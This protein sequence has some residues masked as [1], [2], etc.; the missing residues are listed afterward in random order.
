M[1]DLKAHKAVFIAW[2]EN[3]F[4]GDLLNEEVHD[5]EK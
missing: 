4:T 3:S 5:Q 1:A 2:I